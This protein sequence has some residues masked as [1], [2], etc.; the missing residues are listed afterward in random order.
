MTD[1]GTPMIELRDVSKRFGAQQVLAHA[2]LSIARG[3]T[4]VIIGRSGSGK[5]VMLKHIVGLLQPDAGSV[6]VEGEHIAALERDD[7][8]RVRRKL[9]F[10]FQGAALFDSLSVGEN[11]GLGLVHHTTMTPREIDERVRERLVLV[12]LEGVER[13]YPAELSGGMRKRV[14]VARA[15]AMDPAIVLY[16]EPTTGL[17]PI[18]SDVINELILRLQHT[19]GITSVVVTHDMTSAYK[20]GNHVA[21]LYQGAIIFH[22]TPEAVKSTDNPYVRQFIEGRATGP[23]RL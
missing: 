13:K 19:L 4:M 21:M 14:G 8:F 9:G 3:E 12:G 22:G 6:Y 2:S 23:I 5:S 20:V 15:I 18:M 7:L 16:D 11:V 1:A 10:V 17:D